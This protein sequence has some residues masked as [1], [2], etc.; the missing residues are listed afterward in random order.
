MVAPLLGEIRHDLP[1]GIP[2]VGA[3]RHAVADAVIGWG[4]GPED[5][6]GAELLVSELV[7]N[8]VLYGYGADTLTLKRERNRLRICVSDRSAAVPTPRAPSD[9]AEVGLGMQL[10]AAYA[11][12]WGVEPDENGKTVWCEVVISGR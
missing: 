3:A 8:A 12:E 5:V 10:I 1:L 4:G 9:D 2:A 11:A 7:T 6:A